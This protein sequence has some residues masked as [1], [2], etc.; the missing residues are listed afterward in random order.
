MTSINVFGTAYIENNINVGENVNVGN[1]LRVYELL[2]VLKNIDIHNYGFFKEDLNFY[3]DIMDIKK[4]IIHIKKPD[5]D[6]FTIDNN[7]NCYYDSTFENLNAIK[8]STFTLLDSYQGNLNIINTL[9]TQRI[10]NTVN[11]FNKDINKTTSSFARN[12]NTTHDAFMKDCTVFQINSN[13][14][15]T[16]K[17]TVLNNLNCD[18]YH[19]LTVKDTLKVKR[20][21][22]VSNNINVHNSVI[23]NG[24][25]DRT[26]NSRFV[27]PQ[28][29]PNK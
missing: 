8:D 27:L 24:K 29:N 15:S 10:Y 22:S 26:H 14:F 9:N 21:I 3:K 25:M 4:P 13:N 5:E 11:L 12:L 6:S 17:L 16:E 28:V 1:Y 7:L 18:E 19:L 23:I 2:G 20:F